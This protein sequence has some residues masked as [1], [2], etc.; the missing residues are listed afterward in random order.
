VGAGVAVAPQ[1]A[2]MLPS[3]RIS[4]KIKGD[5]RVCVFMKLESV[6]FEGGL[7]A[8]QYSRF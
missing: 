3:N 4:I 8:I 7:M 1:A 6:I 2:K 5:L